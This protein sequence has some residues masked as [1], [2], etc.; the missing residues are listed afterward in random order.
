[1]E[2]LLVGKLMIDPG[3]DMWMDGWSE[4]FDRPQIG[5]PEGILDGKFEKASRWENQKGFWWETGEMKW[6]VKG[7]EVWLDGLK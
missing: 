6:S 2:G 7:M 4:N 5:D 1:M 3:W